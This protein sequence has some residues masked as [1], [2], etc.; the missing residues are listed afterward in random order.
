MADGARLDHDSGVPIV[1]TVEL[2]LMQSQ[3]KTIQQR[4]KVWRHTGWSTELVR[5]SLQKIR[6]GYWK[7]TKLVWT[8]DI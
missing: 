7:F 4:G 3:K 2:S 8:N 6:T 5:H 1:R